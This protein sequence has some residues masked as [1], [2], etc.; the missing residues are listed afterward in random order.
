MNMLDLATNQKYM[1]KKPIIDMA[2]W[3]RTQIANLWNLVSAATTVTQNA[4]K[5]KHRKNVERITRE[6]E[7]S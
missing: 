6:I 7:I 3:M 2:R 5:H 4:Q 1:N